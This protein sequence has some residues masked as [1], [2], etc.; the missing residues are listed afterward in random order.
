[1]K[2]KISINKHLKTTTHISYINEKPDYWLYNNR[3]LN[4]LDFKCIN[5]QCLN[6][7]FIF[8]IRV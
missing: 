8:H 3:F 2:N 4:L 7:R 5:I 6:Y 1:M